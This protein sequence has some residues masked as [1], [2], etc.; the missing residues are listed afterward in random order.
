[1]AYWDYAGRIWICI[2][3]HI[4]LKIKAWPTHLQNKLNDTYESQLEPKNKRRKNMLPLIESS[5]YFI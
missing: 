4:S 2:A 1:M 3:I 5:Y